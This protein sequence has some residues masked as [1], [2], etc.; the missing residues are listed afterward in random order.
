MSRLVRALAACLIIGG[1]TVATAGN[2]HVELRCADAR[3]CA[4]LK[5][6]LSETAPLPDPLIL[7]LVVEKR[8]GN[9]M[10]AHLAWDGVRQGRGESMGLDVMDTTLR[11][12]MIDRFIVDLVRHTALPGQ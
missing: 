12:P 9:A 5:D 4:A 6:A 7:T 10:T 2:S 1:A 3:M 11:A 8:T